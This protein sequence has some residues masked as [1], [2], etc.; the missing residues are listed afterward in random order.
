MNVGDIAPDFSLLNQQG[1]EFNLY[2]NLNKN[3]LLIF[4]PKDNTL[5]CSNQLRDYQL[6][7]DKFSKINVQLVA[8]NIADKE[9]H[10]NFCDNIDIKFPVL[11]DSDKKISKQ[12]NALNLFGQ[13][14]R[15]IVLIAKDKKIKLIRK[16]F[17]ITYLTTDEL[18]REIIALPLN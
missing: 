12:Y 15:M 1:E 8:I 5:V 3:V 14:K 13:N 10:K 4:Y 7:I 6:N 9:T 2:K 18:V 17:P 16:M 11:S